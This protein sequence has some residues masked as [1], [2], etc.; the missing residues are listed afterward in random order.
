MFPLQRHS[1][2]LCSVPQEPNNCFAPSGFYKEV[3][4]LFGPPGSLGKDVSLDYVQAIVGYQPLA[5][6]PSEFI[7]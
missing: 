7:D 1:S 2:R 3:N 5:G 4:R 6:N